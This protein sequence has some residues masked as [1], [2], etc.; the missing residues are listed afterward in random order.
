M[1]DKIHYFRAMIRTVIASQRPWLTDIGRRWI[2]FDLT[3]SPVSSGAQSLTITLK[4][5]VKQSYEEESCGH[6][7]YL[8]ARVFKLLASHFSWDEHLLILLGRELHA[9][10]YPLFIMCSVIFSANLACSGEL[11]T[12]GYLV[13]DLVVKSKRKGKKAWSWKPS[14]FCK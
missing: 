2:T 3:A 7:L 13:T 4:T 12:A 1:D 11:Q 8:P 9:I 6:C 5:D 14:L 10:N